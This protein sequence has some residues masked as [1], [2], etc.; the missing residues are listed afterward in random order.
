MD[1]AER[2]YQEGGAALFRNLLW[3]FERGVSDPDQ[4]HGDPSTKT[5]IDIQPRPP[6]TR[7]VIAGV[8][9]L[10]AGDVIPQGQR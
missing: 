7:L 6:D 8:D 1:A 10:I 4:S 3:L 9:R 5:D 2:R